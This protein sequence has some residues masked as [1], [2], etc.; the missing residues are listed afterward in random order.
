MRRV[1]SDAP[2]S[3]G[4]PSEA[5]QIIIAIIIIIVSSSSSRSNSSSSSSSSSSIDHMLGII[6]GL[7]KPVPI[8]TSECS[9]ELA[10][11]NCFFQIRED[12]SC[13]NV[14][15]YTYICIYVYIYIYIYIYRYIYIYT[16]I[17]I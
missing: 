1:T 2:R 6:I 3:A 9:K 12:V 7:W 8:S 16:Y 10:R 4:P 13:L 14:C 11:N 17:Y 5:V 15:I